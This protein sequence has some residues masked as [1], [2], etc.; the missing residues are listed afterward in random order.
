MLMQVMYLIE[1][2]HKLSAHDFNLVDGIQL[3]IE[4]CSPHTE[5]SRRGRHVH[6]AENW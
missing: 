3:Q 6:S 5:R 2:R 1:L 4:E